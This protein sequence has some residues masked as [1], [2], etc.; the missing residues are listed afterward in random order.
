[1]ETI[2]WN[3]FCVSLR[4]EKKLFPQNIYL[5]KIFSKSLKEIII[6]Q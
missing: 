3:V 2:G 1:M 6:I 5:N 4:K